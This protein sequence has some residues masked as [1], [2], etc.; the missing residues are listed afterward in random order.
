MTVLLILAGLLAAKAVKDMLNKQQVAIFSAD[1]K[2]VS[3]KLTNV[4]QLPF[5]SKAEK[6]KVNTH[7]VGATL[8]P[9]NPK[10]GG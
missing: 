7:F 8:G 2:R 10:G 3:G 5:A 1:R 6:G 9:S 4:T